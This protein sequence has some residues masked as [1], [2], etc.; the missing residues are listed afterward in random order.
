MGAPSQAGSTSRG[1][2]TLGAAIAAAF[3]YLWALLHA[4]SQWAVG[5]LLLLALVAMLGL[6]R[7]RWAEPLGVAANASPRFLGV[8]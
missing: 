6:R 5:G 4:E 1:R 3:A 8:G 7:L 2:V